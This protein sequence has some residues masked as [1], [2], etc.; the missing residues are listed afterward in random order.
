MAALALDALSAARITGGRPRLEGLPT[1]LCPSSAKVN[2]I[3]NRQL[4]GFIA[5][6]LGD[7][8]KTLFFIKFE[9]LARHLVHILLDFLVG[10]TRVLSKIC[11]VFENYFRF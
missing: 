8:P 3:W 7:K 2:K 9:N 1:G 11:R 10:Y 6:A 5:G 4:A